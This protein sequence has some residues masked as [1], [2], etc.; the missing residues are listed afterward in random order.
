MKIIL[1]IAVLCSIVLSTGAAE[2]CDNGGFITVDIKGI[3][4]CFCHGAG[5]YGPHCNIPCPLSFPSECIII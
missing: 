3:Q 5:F 4:N 1:M 2:Y